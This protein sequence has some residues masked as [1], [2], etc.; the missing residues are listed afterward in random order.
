M[1]DNQNKK[2]ISAISLVGRDRY[3]QY[4]QEL[5]AQGTIAGEQL[6]PSERKEAFKKRNNKV[7]FKT[8]VERV[9]QKKAVA[10]AKIKPIGVRSLPAAGGA[11][12]KYT[13]Q[14]ESQKSSFSLLKVLNSILDT[15]KKQF[16]FD[17][18]KEVD[19]KKEEEKDARKKRE[20]ALEG[21][22]KIS[23]KIL[24]KVIA[25]F[26]SIFDRIWNFIFYT[27]LGRAF[28]QLTNWLGDPKNAQKVQVLGRFLK[29]WW[30][31]L[32]GLYFMPFRGFMLKTLGR[33]AGF[34]A[35]FTARKLIFTPAGAAVGLAAL[36]N[37]VTGQRKAAAVQTE[38]KAKAQTGK[39]LGVRG[40]DTM[41][42]KSPSVGDLGPTTPYGLLQGVSS[43]GLINSNTGM[44]ISGA[45][46]DTQLTALQP[47]EIVMNRAAV[48]GVGAERLL[49]LNSM[50]G[51]SNANRPRFANNIQ[52][53]QNGGLIGSLGR[54]LPGTG[55]VMAPKTIGNQTIA[56]YQD[57]LLG[58]N[59]GKTRY[60][61][62]IY[63]YGTGYSPEQMRR[64]EQVNT[65][66]QFANRGGTL[67]ALVN[68]EN[69][70]G[71]AFRNFGRNVQTI[72]DA[73][74]RQEEM[75]RQMGH[76]P[77]GY[78]NLS[79]QPIRRQGGGIIPQGP[80][81]PLPAPG[82]VRPQGS[83][84]PKPMLHLPGPTPGSRLPF[85]YDP[86][87]GLIGGGLVGESTGG[88]IKGATADRQLTALQPGEYV[89]PVDTVNNVGKSL[90]DKLVAMTDGNS[91][92][93]KLGMRNKRYMPGPLSRGPRGGVI[94]LPPI[95]QSAGG[96]MPMVTSGTQVPSF[97]AVSP[98][99]GA[100][101]LNNASI[102]GIV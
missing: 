39:G 11:L 98:S 40:T 20:D 55:T 99:G 3:D 49:A 28:T 13:P 83:F 65:K 30:P 75:M 78:V 91:N 4:I 18:K 35:K 25:P 73:A 48:K 43:G 16:K 45:G 87:R 15:L 74:K 101:R 64:Y 62:D 81:T 59:I 86:F 33:I 95:T 12:I 21:V 63:G 93:A 89:L 100:D 17:K 5:S 14:Q 36:A 38:S 29:D 52:F 80:F 23:G 41:I 34:S 69:F 79:G 97:S 102:Y 24:D 9:L 37:E 19:D 72:K 84:I 32:L 68:R 56:G 1:A 96:S 57:Q 47:G 82:Y 27:L 53:A 67:P 2:R 8:F 94:N 31:A 88:N 54:F 42:D 22:K 44:R 10:S 50:F 61:K 92:P 70:V 51:G 71:D 46:P 66:K 58:I 7:A 90:I 76:K 6:S 77:D 60:P 85:G 26:K